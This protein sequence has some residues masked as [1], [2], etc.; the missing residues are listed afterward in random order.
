MSINWGFPAVHT[1]PA[2]EIPQRKPL[3]EVHCVRFGRKGLEVMEEV[4]VQEHLC[5]EVLGTRDERID[6]WQMGV[7]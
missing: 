3:G 4:V 7:S 1:N 5:R 6:I 2:T